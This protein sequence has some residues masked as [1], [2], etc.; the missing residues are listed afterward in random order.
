MNTNRGWTFIFTLLAMVL[1]LTF[2]VLITERRLIIK[3]TSRVLIKEMQSESNRDGD[4]WTMIYRYQVNGVD[5]VAFLE[6]VNG[7]GD[8]AAELE[9]HRAYLRQFGEIVNEK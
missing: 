8:L 9:E 2:V 3:E 6:D 5:S 1:G 4:T 7:D